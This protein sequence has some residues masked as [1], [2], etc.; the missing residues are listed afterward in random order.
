MQQVKNPVSFA[1]NKTILITGISKGIGREIASVF[2]ANGFNV[3]GCARD[4]K[5]LDTFKTELWNRYPEQKFLLATCNVADKA[6]LLAF[7][8]DVQDEF[9]RVDVLVNNA[10]VFM[11]GGVLTEEEGVLENLLDVNLASAY[12]L[13]REFAPQM[14]ARRRGHIFNMCSVAGIKGYPN[15]GSYCISK[16]ALLGL[17][18]SLREELK[19]YSVKVSAIIAGATLTQSWEGSGL[20]EERFMP[21][22]DIARSIW[23]IYELS[24][25]TDVEEIILRPQLGDI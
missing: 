24:D 12:H 4:K 5:T 13:C 16:H 8:S 15:G 14:I 2:A 25:N 1:M 21:A 23:S 3:A 17:S 7:A 18:R 11:P 20:P 9:E 19:T 6:D 10:G 22:G